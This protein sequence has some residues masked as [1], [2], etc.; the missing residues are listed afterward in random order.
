MVGWLGDRAKAF[1]STASTQVPRKWE[2]GLNEV[3][4]ATRG[5]AL[6]SVEAPKI[7][8]KDFNNKL[9]GCLMLFQRSFGPLRLELIQRCINLGPDLGQR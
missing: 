2:G 1:Q 8:P 3:G 9:M 6:G 7:H 5:S 4:L